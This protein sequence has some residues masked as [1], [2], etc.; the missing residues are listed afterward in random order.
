MDIVAHD[1]LV[2][3]DYTNLLL[4]LD[5]LVRSGF[6]TLYLLHSV[7][8]VNEGAVVSRIGDQK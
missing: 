8:E 1:I 4:R 6:F 2:A 5:A 7:D 3:L